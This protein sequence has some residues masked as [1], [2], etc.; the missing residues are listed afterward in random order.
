MCSMSGFMHIEQTIDV[1]IVKEWRRLYQ[2]LYFDKHQHHALQL[3]SVKSWLEPW[4]NLWWPSFWELR[5]FSVHTLSLTSSTHMSWSLQT[6]C[7]VGI[8]VYQCSGENVWTVMALR[9]VQY[10]NFCTP[11]HFEASPLSAVLFCLTA[12]LGSGQL[13]WKLSRWVCA[14]IKKHEVPSSSLVHF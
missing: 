8:V 4:K 14:Q 7:K 6:S 1:I 11:Q 12:W 10:A 9:W 13:L 3:T 2:S 5:V